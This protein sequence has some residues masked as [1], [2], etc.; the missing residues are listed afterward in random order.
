[1]WKTAALSLIFAACAAAGIIKKYCLK[2]RCAELGKMIMLAEE[3][4]NR[5]T[6]ENAPILKILAESSLSKDICI[7]S[8]M[9][10]SE[11][12]SLSE[13]YAE[14]R[15]TCLT[16]SSF[17]SADWTSVDMLFGNL[18]KTDIEGQ[19]CLIERTVSELENRKK[20]A[21]EI[22][23]KYGNLY[24]KIGFAAGIFAVILCI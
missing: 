3:L 6:Y 22:S 17:D 4:K 2:K 10:A 21:Y 23:E 20:S 5:I 18:G 14:A 9:M 12:A 8:G 19:R 24:L 7:I 13:K 15:R 1:M 16:A 11:K